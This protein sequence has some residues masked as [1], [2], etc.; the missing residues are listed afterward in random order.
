MRPTKSFVSWPAVL[1][2]TMCLGLLG[3]LATFAVAEENHELPVEGRVYLMENAASGNRVIVLERALD[4][5]LKLLQEVETGGLGSGPGELP[6]PF[7]PGLPGPNPLDSQDALI[8]TNNGRFLIAANAGSNDVSVLAITRDGLELV[9]REPSG[10][11]FPVSIAHHH[12]TIYVINNGGRNFQ[13]IVGG[14]P[15]LKGFHL[16]EDGKLH[17]ISGSTRVIG[18]DMAHPGDAIFS[19][20]G[21]VLFVSEQSTNTIELFHVALDGSVHDQTSVHASTDTPFGMAFGHDNLLAVTAVNGL[22]VGVEDG[23]TISSY[24]LTER[25]TLEEI[26]AAVPTK[27]SAACWVRFTPDGNFAFIANPGSGS[28]TSF[29]VSPSGELTL[30][31]PVAADVGGH[32]SGPLDLDITANGKYL[33]VIGSFIGTVQGYRIEHDGSLTHVASFGG[34]PFTIQGL[35]VR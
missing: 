11:I 15:T 1:R 14:T 30:L 35:V 23:A 32:F 25:G 27:Q 33:Y 3:L 9:D 21:N 34:L 28:V 5:R 6:P 13:T 4:G 8:I 29:L 24:R 22:P 12:D 7:P 17:E 16:D 2:Y 31:A 19:P 10:G 26:S 20:N 18:P